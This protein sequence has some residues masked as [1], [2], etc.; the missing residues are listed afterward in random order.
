[1]QKRIITLQ[2]NGAKLR[3]KD[4]LFQVSMADPGLNQQ[5]QESFPAHEVGCINFYPGTSNSSDSMLLATQNDVPVIFFDYHGNVAAH[6]F[7]S[8]PNRTIAIWRRQLEY[9]QSSKGLI[10]ARDWIAEKF[11]NRIAFLQSLH[12][13]RSG[14]AISLLQRAAQGLTESRDRLLRYHPE[15]NLQRAAATIRGIEGTAGRQYYECLGQILPE[16]Y[17]FN[18]RTYRP[19]QDLF[20]ACLNYGHAILGAQVTN[21]L[22]AAGINPYIGF[23][24]RD[25]LQQTALTY[26]FIEPFRVLVE[27]AV[28]GLFSQKIISGQYGGYEEGKGFWLNK[29][30]CRLVSTQVN[31]LLFGAPV[32]TAPPQR[33]LLRNADLNHSAQR[34]SAQ[35]H[36]T[37]RN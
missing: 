33:R 24:H 29:Q 5:R 26:D 20:N 16:G 36:P 31:D 9:A 2:T 34:L 14:D 6:V 1:M 3:V 30:G 35:L 4:G 11:Q 10:F 19:A 37:Q 18:G 27:R 12:K 23:M 13:R 15:E 22:W 8:K 28:F 32:A 21:H 25:G 17:R 7:P